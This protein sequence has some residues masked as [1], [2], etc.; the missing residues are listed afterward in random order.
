MEHES[1]HLQ[2][3]VPTRP[4]G[5]WLGGA[6][7]PMVAIA[8]HSA[9]QLTLWL[10]SLRVNIYYSQV[11]QWLEHLR[12]VEF[13]QSVSCLASSWRRAATASMLTLRANISSG[14]TLDTFVGW[15]T[16]VR[17]QLIQWTLRSDGTKEGRVFGIYYSA[18]TN[19]VFEIRDCAEADQEDWEV[20][21]CQVC[22][23][24]EFRGEQ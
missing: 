16:A 4:T 18:K 8:R 2:R 11:G 21:V 12:G 9:Y 14:D 19:L 10:S 20:L 24:P 3:D 1:V 6:L 5:T 22:V 17:K 7:G 13:E 23:E 15:F